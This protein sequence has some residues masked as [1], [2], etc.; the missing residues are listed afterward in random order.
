M[1][2]MITAQIVLINEDGLVLGV[3]RKDDHND[4]GLPGGKM[5]EIDGGQPNLTAIRE[6]LEETGLKVTNL[7]QI[8]SIHKN[9]NMGYTFLGDYDNNALIDHNEPH[10]V[11]W[12]PFQRLI[13]GRFGKYNKMVSESLDSMGVKYQKDIDEELMGREVAAY[14]LV[15][16]DGEVIF[17]HLY[18]DVRYG[19]SV[20]YDIHI[21][22]PEG[23]EFEDYELEEAFD[24]SERVDNELSAIGLKYGVNLGLSIDYSSK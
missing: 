11:K 20:S 1:E 4:F 5:E 6:T 19:G 12:V 10:V 18:K 16:F 7:R 14:I 13:N 15:E 2:N 24:V 22:Y 3:S 17:S 9:G 23:S 8:F 21:G